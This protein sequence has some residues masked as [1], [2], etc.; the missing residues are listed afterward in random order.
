MN[1]HVLKLNTDG[2]W[3]DKDRAVG[4]GGLFRDAQGEWCLGFYGRL[5]CSTSLEANIW[6]IYKGLTI[7]LEKGTASV[8]IESDALLAVKL[9]NEGPNAN[10]PLSTI[11]NYARTIIMGTAS[12]L[13]HVYR[14]ANECSDHLARVGP[15][16]AEDFK[17][18]MNS[19]LSIREFLIRDNLSIR[20]YLN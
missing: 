15:E 8:K 17:I 10:H 13:T 16:Q 11:I 19:P 18:L 9:I 2:G 6:G 14:G 20:Q 12:S 5:T 4:Y 7:I 1:L 3:Y